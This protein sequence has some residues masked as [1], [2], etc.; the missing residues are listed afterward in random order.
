M[1]AVMSTVMNSVTWG[2]VNAEATIAAAVCLRTPLI[3]M[4]SSRP[5][6]VAIDADRGSPEAVRWMSSRVM[7][8]FGPV[9]VIAVRST[10]RSLAYLRTGGLASTV[11]S[12]DRAGAGAAS[13]VRAA[14]A[15]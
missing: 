1:V 14:S 3:G 7:V 5:A 6:G 2:A 10:P 4:R 15:V 11:T 8:P 12:A 9:G 13:T